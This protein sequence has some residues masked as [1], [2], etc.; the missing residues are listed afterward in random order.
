MA[1]DPASR[2]AKLFGVLEGELLTKITQDIQSASNVPNLVQMLANQQY[3]TLAN[4]VSVQVATQLANHYTQAFMVSGKATADFLSKTMGVAVSFNHTNDR[5]V[6]RVQ[7]NQLKLVREISA[8]QRDVIRAALEDGVRRGLNPIDQ[9]RNFRASIGLTLSQNEWVKNYREALERSSTGT[10]A[11]L[12]RQLRDRRFDSSVRGAARGRRVPL[13]Q[14]EI[15]RMVGRYTE[16][17]VKYRSEVIA[18]TEALRAVNEAAD[19]MYRQAITNG[20]IKK[21]SVIRKWVAARDER[22]RGSHRTLH[23]QKRK[24]DQPWQTPNGLIRFPGDPQA[25]AAETIQCRCTVT[26]RFTPAARQAAQQA[27]AQPALTPKADLLSSPRTQKE[28]GDW[29]DGPT[30]TKRRN[31][32]QDRPDFYNEQTKE[33]N[34]GLHQKDPKWAKDAERALAWRNPK[35]Q[36]E[37]TRKLTDGKSLTNTEQGT[38]NAI[39]RAAQ[40]L[41]QRLVTY[42]GLD[43]GQKNVDFKLGQVLAS[44]IPKSS[45]VDLRRGV[46]FSNNDT[47]L[48]IHTKKGAKAFLL[49]QN[50][51]E[52]LFPPG[53]RFRVVGVEQNVRIPTLTFKRPTLKRLVRVEALEPD[54]PPELSVPSKP[55]PKPAPTRT[56]TTTATYK[57][58]W[59]DSPKTQQEW[60]NWYDGARAGLRR[61][62]HRELPDFY[63]QFSESRNDGLEQRD[64]Q[65]GVIAERASS[66]V[67][68]KVYSRITGKILSGKKLGPTDQDIV[69]AVTKASRPLSKQIVTFRGMRLKG[70]DVEFKPGQV[71]AAPTPTSTSFNLQTSASFSGRDTIWEIHSRPG[72]KGFVYNRSESEVLYPVGTKF[73]I[74]E[75]RD[76]FSF[77]GSLGGEIKFRQYVRVEVLAPG[78]TGE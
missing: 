45:S 33:R 53:T 54:Q 57:P 2:L 1:V 20:Q 63:N 70:K 28:W 46:R 62:E 15:D 75:V 19:E 41:S 51:Q 42:R 30:A 31:D 68:N 71:W 21:D 32:F 14:A 7:Q 12:N 36:T 65:Y 24:I 37:I 39:T 74:A 78:E 38:L 58:A 4:T 18:R 66:W 40:P 72:A 10:T 35:V 43:L 8:Q 61:N 77:R 69:N 56:R 16:R 13:S 47:L 27:A 44:P 48:E 55:K 17:A 76:D 22:T 25:P 9:A 59:I 11:A 6:Q 64:P 3:Q 73:R 49:G 29:Y 52:V 60:G 34:D 50:Q 23:G 26:I 5:A 67:R